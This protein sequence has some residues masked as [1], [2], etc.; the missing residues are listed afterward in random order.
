MVFFA[1]LLGFLFGVFMGC[2][3]PTYARA[4]AVSGQIN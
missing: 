4:P 2:A 3:S 1:D